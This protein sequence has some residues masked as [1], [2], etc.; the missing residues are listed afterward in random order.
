MKACQ[1]TELWILGLDT[2]QTGSLALLPA[3]RPP[4]ASTNPLFSAA[5]Q[6][7]LQRFSITQSRVQNRRE[8][9]K[10]LIWTQAR[11]EMG[12]MH[13]AGSH[14]ARTLGLCAAH[15]A[16]GHHRGSPS[17]ARGAGKGRVSGLVG[18]VGALK[19][20]PY[21]N[22]RAGLAEI[23]NTPRGAP[24]GCCTLE[25]WPAGRRRGS[26]A[27][28]PQPAKS[29]DL[30]PSPRPRPTPSQLAPLLAQLAPCPSEDHGD[31]DRVAQRAWT[32]SILR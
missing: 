18:R 19:S 10:Q 13:A 28:C 27:A 16:P 30:P 8:P 24:R 23:P 2:L 21:A 20:S 25:G 6:R 5:P 1:M 17:C 7:L 11:V 9:A 29:P 31:H 22:L 15:K 4:R 14:P 32:R 3:L 26:Q 12:D